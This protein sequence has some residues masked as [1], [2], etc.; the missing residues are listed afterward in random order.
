MGR[1]G[2]LR[3][4]P[5]DPVVEREDDRDAADQQQDDGFRQIARRERGN[6]NAERGAGHEDF[7]I[8][9]V[10]AV[11]IGPDADHVHRAENRQHDARR[12][13]RRHGERHERYAQNA[14]AACEPSLGETDDQHGGDGGCVKPGI[15]NHGRCSSGIW[16]PVQ[17][18]GALLIAAVPV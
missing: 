15:G 1:F 13:Q 7:Q 9:P 14:K 10:E 17:P 18:I 12:L 3:G 2:R 5:A 16:R 11:A 4:A 6:E 8:V